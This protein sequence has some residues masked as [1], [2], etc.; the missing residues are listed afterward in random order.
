MAEKLTSDSLDVCEDR[1]FQDKM[2]TAQRVGWALMLL[3]LV[4]ALLGATGG[5]GP[6]AMARVETPEGTIEYPRVTRWQAAADMTVTLPPGTGAKAELH[7]SN[8][9]IKL[10]HVETVTPEPS[11]TVATPAGHRFTFDVAGGGP[12]TIVFHV[13][14]SKPSLMTRAQTKIGAGEPVRLA[15]T[16]LP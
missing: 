7:L 2:W 8:E 16:V 1:A 10:F 13:R 14:A 4:A 9:L 15:V 11:Q 5:G 3:F 12:K 6:L